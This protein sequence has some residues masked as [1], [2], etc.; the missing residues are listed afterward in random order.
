MSA[1]LS[2]SGCRGVF[3]FRAALEAAL[4]KAEAIGTKLPPYRQS[5]RPPSAR[6][7]VRAG[8]AFEPSFEYRRCPVCDG[9]MNR[10]NFLKRSGVIVDRCLHHGTWFDAGEAQHAAE[11][12][13]A[14]SK[15]PDAG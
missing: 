10:E 9:T 12:M 13:A 6:E 15:P 3:L 2:C 11:F 5:S 4:A 14:K 8:G 7:S 1:G